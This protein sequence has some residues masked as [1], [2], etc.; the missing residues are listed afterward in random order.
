MPSL[1][2]ARV[3]NLVRRDEFLL[4]RAQADEPREQVSTA[5]LIVGA[6]CT[7][8]AEGLLADH[9]T[10]ALAVDVEVTRGVAE[11]ILRNPDGLAVL[12]ED[13]ACETVLTGLVNL[14]ADL[15]EVG[16][17][18]VVVGVHNQDG[19][20]ELAGE[21]RVIGV[22]GAVNGGLNVPALGGVIGTA[23]EELEF[24]VA[25]GLLDDLSELVEGGF[26]D[27]GAAEVGEVGGLADLELLCFGH[28]LL[29]ELI[30]DGGCDVRAGGGAA[31][32]SLEL[33]R[34]ADGLHGSVADVRRLVDEVEVLATSFADDARVAAVFA[35][36]DPLS[37]F[38]VQGTEH[39]GASGE[40]QGSEFAVVEYGV[41]D[42]FGI[43][44]DELYDVLGQ[45]CFQEDLVNQPVGRDGGG[46]RL[47]DDNITHQSRGA[48]QITTDGSEVEGADGIDETFEGTVFNAAALVS[49]C[50]P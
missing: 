49:H 7:G 16:L 25:L 28:N 5:G 31:L 50:H 15:G 14:L 1:R 22:R 11:S 27:D 48:G 32:L 33:K 3:L 2:I 23:D 19:A 39:G 10:G 45:S 29:E 37:D 44:G 18:G 35:L 34:S 30:G 36:G 43:A 46:G 4:D 9:G 8:T 47:P 42:F 38:S 12:R 24:R 41:G 13:G 6:A 20:K 40:M 17:C 21:E 26:V